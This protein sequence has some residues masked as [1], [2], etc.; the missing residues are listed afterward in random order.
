MACTNTTAVRKLAS[1]NFPP[2]FASSSDSEHYLRKSSRLQLGIF[3]SV[4]LEQPRAFVHRA[5][6][7]S[8]RVLARPHPFP[9][10]ADFLNREITGLGLKNSGSREDHSHH[11]FPFVSANNGH[12]CDMVGIFLE[13]THLIPACFPVCAFHVGYIRKDPDGP[14]FTLSDYEFNL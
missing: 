1:F 5:Y 2:E 11:F 8:I 3:R 14:R 9:G 6:R 7:N 10:S 4:A 13:K 12:A